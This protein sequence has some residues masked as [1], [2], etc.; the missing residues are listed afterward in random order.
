MNIKEYM[1][2]V[3]VSKRKYV[4]EWVAQG[5]IPGVKEDEK[6]GE[7]FFPPSAR[8]PYRPHF[9]SKEN[10]TVIR[11]SILN[12][13]LKRE[14]ISEKIYKM[15]RGEFLSFIDDLKRADL[16]KVRK[17]DGIDYYDS[18]VKSDAYRNRSIKEIRK[19]ILDCLESASY[20]AT[21]AIC[22]K[23]VAA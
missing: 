16:I 4:E 21:K 13:C 2:K 8:R 7:L 22:E 18:T 5:L 17:E 14:Y 12:A 6:T 3:G 10:A 23:I 19:F 20:G 11:A 1:K 15:S 9:K